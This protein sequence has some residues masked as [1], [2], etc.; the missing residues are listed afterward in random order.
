M[1]FGVVQQAEHLSLVT[2]LGS[3]S[4]FL[5][6]VNLADIATQYK[7]VVS[8]FPFTSC[9]NPDL[10]PGSIFENETLFVRLL[11]APLNEKPELALLLSPTELLK[12]SSS[13]I[14]LI[15]GDKDKTL[16]IK[17]SLFMMEVAK[18]K[19]ADV[20]LLTVENAGHSFK[21][22]DISP[23]ME[24]LNDYAAKYILSHLKK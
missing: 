9:L 19:K 24:E 12:E 23:S 14:L 5:G 13:P 20:Q 3:D 10:R 22:A 1:V 6:D 8:Y 11:G 2:A 16:P 15:H 17:N 21:G 7:C 4:D 18:K